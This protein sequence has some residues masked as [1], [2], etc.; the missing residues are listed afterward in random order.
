MEKIKTSV[1]DLIRISEEDKATNE[2]FLNALKQF[3]SGVVTP[4]KDC[5]D[6][7]CGDNVEMFKSIS[8]SFCKKCGFIYPF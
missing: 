1:L 2:E 6:N 7:L 5:D 4:I 3:S 8:G